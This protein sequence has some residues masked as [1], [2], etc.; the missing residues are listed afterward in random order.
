MKPTRTDD[1]GPLGSLPRLDPRAVA[2]FGALR[3]ASIAAPLA[4]A[5][6]WL[7]AP[8]GDSIRIGPVEVLPRVSGL[9]RPGAIARLSSPSHGTHLGLGLETSLAHALVDRA[10]GY[11][12]GP[13]ADRLQITP[14]EFGVLTYLAARTLAELKRRGGPDLLLERLGPDPL[15]VDTLGPMLTLRWLVRIGST[16]AVA[17]MWLPWTLLR[18][19]SGPTATADLNPTLT[20][21]LA[22][23]TSDWRAVAGSAT[24]AR[25]GEAHRRGLVLPIDNAP[26]TGTPASPFGP[27]ALTASGH[28]ARARLDAVPVPRSGAGRLVL[29]GP[30]R[31]EPS[32][33]E[34]LAM[35]AQPSPETPD[36]ASAPPTPDLPVTLAVELGRVTMTVA[37]VSQL[38]PGDVIE[39]GRHAREPVELTSG[40]RLVA[41][42][43]LV[44]IDNELG[45][46][47]TRVF[48]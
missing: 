14:V 29:S 48:L 43:E 9:K 33:R 37:R 46:R 18:G 25:G 1:G 22:G 30:I 6:D 42:G 23:L 8:L 35:T 41:S 10:L 26:L 4:R 12:R 19:L 32:P 39:L 44:Q 34:P 47:V 31:F 11:D 38:A 16:S 27:I 24:M 45:V 3:N 36:D 20:T 7:T 2:A 13:G 28:P 17:R 21:A 40:G 15:A 5:L